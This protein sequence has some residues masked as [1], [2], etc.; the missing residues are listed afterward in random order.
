MNARETINQ[1]EKLGS[2]EDLLLARLTEQLHEMKA[3]QGEIDDF[4]RKATEMRNLRCAMIVETALTVAEVTH[5]CTI[6]QLRARTMLRVV[7]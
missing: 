1:L 2:V 5:G 6:H 7:Q 3:A 4:L